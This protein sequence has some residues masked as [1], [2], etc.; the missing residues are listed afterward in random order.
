MQF[1]ELQPTPFPPCMVTWQPCL[2]PESWL[3]SLSMNILVLMPF[4]NYS[5]VTTNTACKL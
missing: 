4:S 5:T 3:L 2:H 1:I